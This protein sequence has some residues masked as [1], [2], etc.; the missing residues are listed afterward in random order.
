MQ[1]VT[2]ERDRELVLSAVER[3]VSNEQG[4]DCSRH[5]EYDAVPPMC[6]CDAV[7]FELM[8]DPVRC[9]CG[10]DPLNDDDMVSSAFVTHDTLQ[11]QIQTWKQAHC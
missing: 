1:G 8:T 2:D 7:S 9:G 11:E 10:T 6:Y 4:V 3:L 5:V